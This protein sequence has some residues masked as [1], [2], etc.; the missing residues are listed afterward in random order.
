MIIYYVHMQ[1]IQEYNSILYICENVMHC[2]ST[3]EPSPMPN[4]T[5]LFLHWEA[6][7]A[8][9]PWSVGKFRP[10]VKCSKIE[11]SEVSA[12]VSGFS[13]FPFGWYS[14]NVTHRMVATC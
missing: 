11:T 5:A 8:R 13:W 10:K 3:I 2:Y 9:V 7:R 6:K 4:I 14:T 12:E 1:K